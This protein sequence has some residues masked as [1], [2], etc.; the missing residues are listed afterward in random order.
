MKAMRVMRL[1]IRYIITSGFYEFTCQYN[2]PN[3][4]PKKK[5]SSL[6]KNVRWLVVGADTLSSKKRL[7]SIHQL[8]NI[9]QGPM[10]NLVTF[11]LVR[12]FF[13][14]KFKLFGSYGAIFMAIKII[15]IV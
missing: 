6:D 7:L 2:V 14:I 11:Q 1:N 15:I 9:I 8:E 3:F 5:N 10:N 13:M 4:H 12:V